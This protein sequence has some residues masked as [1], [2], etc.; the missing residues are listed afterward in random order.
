MKYFITALIA[1]LFLLGLYHGFFLKD[2]TLSNTYF[3]LGYL[4][5]DRKE[6]Y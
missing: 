5:M 4:L 6:R 2:F 3:I 1:L